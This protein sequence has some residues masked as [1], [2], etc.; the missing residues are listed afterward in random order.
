MFEPE[1]GKCIRDV[2]TVIMHFGTLNFIS[3]YSLE[4]IVVQCLLKR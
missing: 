1:K 3:R 4:S 2:L